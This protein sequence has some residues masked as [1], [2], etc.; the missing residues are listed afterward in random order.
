VKYRIGAA[1][2]IILN[3]IDAAMTAWAL[4]SFPG[5]VRE[6]NPLMAFLIAYAGLW[7]FVFV[8]VAIGAALAVWMEQRRSS[9]LWMGLALVSAVVAW[10]FWR[11]A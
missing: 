6:A 1:A 9:A 8:K 11:L 10:N 3:T 2:F 7:G 4:D 5:E